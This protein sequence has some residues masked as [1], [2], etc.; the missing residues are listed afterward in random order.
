MLE[1]HVKEQTAMRCRNFSDRLGKA[2]MPEGYAIML[3]HDE[4]FFYWLRHDGAQSD[5]HWNKWA[6]YRAAKADS[7]R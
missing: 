3:D 6:V 5:V 1:Q 2:R 4:T 7:N